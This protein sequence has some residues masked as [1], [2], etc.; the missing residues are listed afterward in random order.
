MCVSAN[1][2]I[3]NNFINLNR[4]SATIDNCVSLHIENGQI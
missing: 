2:N 3:S 4:L 1:T